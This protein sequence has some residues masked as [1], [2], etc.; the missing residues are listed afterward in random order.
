MAES[1]STRPSHEPVLTYSAGIRVASP[2]RAAARHWRGSHECRTA[3]GRWAGSGWLNRCTGVQSA[4]EHAAGARHLAAARLQNRNECRRKFQLLPDR[5]RGKDRGRHFRHSV[6]IFFKGHR[7]CQAPVPDTGSAW[8]GSRARA[9][10]VGTGSRVFR[11]RFARWTIRASSA[12]PRCIRIGPGN[13]ATIP[14]SG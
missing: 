3:A 13:T 1:E 6:R 14:I 10:P 5:A 7:S 12:L 4:I 8:Y 9:G 11:H 2:A